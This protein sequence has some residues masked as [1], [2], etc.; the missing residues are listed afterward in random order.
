MEDDDVAVHL[1]LGMQVSVMRLEY[2]D[3][4]R[5]LPRE[6]VNKVPKEMAMI[7]NGIVLTSINKVPV[8]VRLLLYTTIIARTAWWATL[9]AIIVTFR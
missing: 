6:L 3:T 4:V 8:T 1:L 5:S 7:S 9:V 2:E